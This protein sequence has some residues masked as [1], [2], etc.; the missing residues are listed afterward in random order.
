VRVG[1]RGGL[2]RGLGQAGGLG[3]LVPEAGIGQETGAALGV[4]D[5][6]DLEQAV[7]G[8]LPREQLPGEERE[9]GQVLD[10]GL[11]DPSARVAD[12]GRLAEPESEGYRGVNPVVQAGHDDHLGGGRAERYGGVGAGELL[13][14]LEQRGEPGHGRSFR[15][16]VTSRRLRRE[17]GRSGRLP[18]PNAG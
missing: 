14:A 6:R 17:P 1:D 10:D 7:I 11:G 16:H 2:Q 15:C 18:S 5:D 12:D 13:V 8:E 9:V 3:G 4:V